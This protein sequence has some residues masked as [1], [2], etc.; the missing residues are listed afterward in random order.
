MAYLLCPGSAAQQR[1]R[2]HTGHPPNT[3]ESTS[4]NSHAHKCHL[5]SHPGVHARLEAAGLVEAPRALGGSWHTGVP[6]KAVQELSYKRR[7]GRGGGHPPPGTDHSSCFSPSALRALPQ[8][9][10]RS[11]SEPDDSTAQCQEVTARNPRAGQS[12]PPGARLP[13]RCTGRL[14]LALD[15]DQL[16][17]IQGMGRHPKV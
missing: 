16:W 9:S 10:D 11:A 1:P 8:T 14:F 5:T 17:M 13:P 3:L 4:R 6:N 2:G 7:S 12:P 15:A